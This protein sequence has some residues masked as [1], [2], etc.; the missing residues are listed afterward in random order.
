MKRYQNPDIFEHLAISYALGTLQGKAR[1]RFEA[2]Q[3]RHLYLR[4]VTAAWQQQLAP[5]VQLLPETPPPARVWDNISQELGLAQAASVAGTGGWWNRYRGFL[6]WAM[7]GLASVVAAV[8]TVLLLNMDT[9]PE[10][11]M[12]TLKSA[13][14]QDKMMVAMVYHDRMEVAFDMPA[15]TLPETRGMMP[16]LW[17][18][19][20]DNNLPPLRMGSLD[21]GGDRRMS[22]DRKT[23][24]DLASVKEF[25]IS[26]EPMDKP[27]ATQPLGEVVFV[28][29]LKAM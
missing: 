28:G 13:K 26:L 27:P 18:I 23:W 29:K 12:A 19:H 3:A 21:A 11:Y 7:T 14:Q 17:C 4:A 5:L 24:R 20:K 16:T 1:Q 2:L 8:I 9:Q 15:N 6:P 22:I 25:A 10:V